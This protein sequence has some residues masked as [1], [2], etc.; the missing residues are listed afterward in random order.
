MSQQRLSRRRIR[1]VLRLKYG[2]G[3]R[4]HR[5][6]AGILGISHSTVGGYVRRAREA[7]VSWPL[8]EGLDDGSLD[9]ALYPARP[10]S[11]V[12]RPEPG[13]GSGCTGSWRG[14][15]A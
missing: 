6:I 12:P 1:D 11:R 9:A 3:G 15:R 14:T 2:G 8:P 7:G 13:T 10:P 5:E 4:S